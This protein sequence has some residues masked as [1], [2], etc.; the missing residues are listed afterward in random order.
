MILYWDEDTLDGA[1]R[2]SA[3]QAEAVEKQRD[4]WAKSDRGDPYG[5]GEFGDEVALRDFIIFNRAWVGADCVH[6]DDAFGSCTIS[7]SAPNDCNKCD[8]A[9]SRTHYAKE[10]IE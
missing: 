3:S 6:H 10:Q 8:A 9:L 5:P 2:R 4:F 7:R 1:V